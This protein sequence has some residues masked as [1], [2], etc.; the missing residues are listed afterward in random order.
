MSQT[1]LITGASSGIGEQFAHIHA[2][3][4]GDLVLVARRADKLI[5]LKTLLEDKHQIKAFVLVADLAEEGS[6][7]KI[8]EE[9]HALGLTIDILINNA[10]FGGRGVFHEQ[11]WQSN[12]DMI[13]VNI[14]AL[15]QLTRLF[16]PGMVERNRGRVLNV[17]S[18]A[19]ELPGPLQV[20]YFATKAFVTSF[21]NA[22]VEELRDTAVTV[23]AL[24]PGAT[25][26]EFAETSGMAN[27]PLFQNAVPPSSVAE[28]GYAAMM[29]GKLDVVSGIPASR[30]AMYALVPFLPK[31]MLLREVRKTQEQTPS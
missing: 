6:A 28:D 7:E 11:D 24:L 21:S 16:L 22:L 1:A 25:E 17:S 9:V 3:R 8:F 13:Q 10:G 19:G 14:V 2:Q 27:T 15:A 5:S 26:S 4:G 23:T 31:R 18:T 30:R 20:V 29:A 12:R